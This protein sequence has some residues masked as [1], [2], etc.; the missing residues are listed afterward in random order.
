MECVERFLVGATALVSCGGGGGDGGPTAPPVVRH[1]SS[2]RLWV[3]TW[4]PVSLGA[5]STM[6]LSQSGSN[7]TGTV[8]IF[9]NTFPITGTASSSRITWKIPDGGCG[10]LT[11]DG[12]A[13]TP[14]PAQLAGSITFDARG[15]SGGALYNGPIVW[16]RSRASAS[17]EIG[18]RQG[19]SLRDLAESLPR[20]KARG[21]SVTVGVET[22]TLETMGGTVRDAVAATRRWRPVE[23]RLSEY[24]VRVVAVHGAGRRSVADLGVASGEWF[25]DDAQP[26][27]HLRSPTGNRSLTSRRRAPWSSADLVAGYWLNSSK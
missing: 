16:N 11:G 6:T 20:P 17:A 12:S 21:V 18:K 26:L 5:T 10:S 7:L 19:G 22:G 13:S 24:Y 15:C 8:T 3:G 1:T 23:E 14:I 4:Y 25:D 9:N 2:G 27:D